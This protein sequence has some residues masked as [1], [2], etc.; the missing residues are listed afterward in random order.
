MFS[1]PFSPP[2]NIAGTN[3][4]ST[5][6]RLHWEAVPYEHAN[7]LIL[8]YILELVKTHIIYKDILNTSS[9]NI[10]IHGET[11]LNR[12]FTSLEMFTDYT[13]R[14]LAFTSKGNGNFS[15]PITVRTDEDGKT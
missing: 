4:S 13:Y 7:G 15:E 12:V 3:L 6:L 2:V 14:I 8:G 1:V 9:Y 11:T 5:S 10:T